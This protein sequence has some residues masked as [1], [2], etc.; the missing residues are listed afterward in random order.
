MV[1]AL[2]FLACPTA[3]ASHPL[4]IRLGGDEALASTGIVI[5]TLAS[6]VPLALIVATS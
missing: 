4:V 1:I 5:S 3:V 6:A 2:V